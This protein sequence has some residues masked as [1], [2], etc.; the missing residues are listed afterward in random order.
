MNISDM[1]KGKSYLM[2]IGFKEEEAESIQLLRGTLAEAGI[3]NDR[4]QDAVNY[5]VRNQLGAIDASEYWP[6]KE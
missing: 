4:W 5:A 6:N 1:I 3:I 2:D